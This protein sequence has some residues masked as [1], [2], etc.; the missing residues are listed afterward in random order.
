[1]SRTLLT[2]STMTGYTPHPDG[3]MTLRFRTQELNED[4]K[5]DC[6]THYQ[7]FGWLGFVDSEDAT[8]LDIPKDSPQREGKSASQ[9]L[10]A[11]IFILWKQTEGKTTFDQFYDRYMNAIIDKTKEKIDDSAL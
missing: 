10:R 3:T 8:D 9:R 7:Q 4:Q 2:A 6:I 11:V 5:M 1:M